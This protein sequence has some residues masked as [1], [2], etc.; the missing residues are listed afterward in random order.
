MNALTPLAACVLAG[1][2]LPIGLA[3]SEP[4]VHVLAVG[5]GVREL[6]EAFAALEGFF[7]G[8]QPFVLCQVV[9]VLESFGTL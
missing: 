8:V 3:D 6:L 2:L 4:V 9:L 5:A 7:A 1:H